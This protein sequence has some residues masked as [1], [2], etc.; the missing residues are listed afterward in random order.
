VRTFDGIPTVREIG[1]IAAL[2]QCLVEHFSRELDA[3]RAVPRL[4]P[5]FVRENKWRAA[6]YG[7]DAEVI[8]DREGRQRPVAEH[9]REVVE[10]LSPIAVELHC[11]KEFAEVTQILDRG[12]SY[13]R[14]I[15]VA[16]A[17]DGDLREVVRHLIREFRGGPTL[18]EFVSVG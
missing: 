14:Q 4:Q 7:L 18:R 8:V 13:E 3:G 9:L 1:A 6:R 2:T 11:A 5:W 15:R 16:D 17:A 12:A 10:S